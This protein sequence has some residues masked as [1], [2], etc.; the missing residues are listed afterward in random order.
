MDD[1]ETAREAVDKIED[2]LIPLLVVEES[3]GGKR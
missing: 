3:E 2:V 1:D